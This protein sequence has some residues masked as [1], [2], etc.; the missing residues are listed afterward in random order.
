MTWWWQLLALLAA[1]LLERDAREW[2]QEMIYRFT[3]GV[4]DD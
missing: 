4:H 1:L 3:Y 2:E